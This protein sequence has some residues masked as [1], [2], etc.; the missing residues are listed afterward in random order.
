MLWMN[1]LFI[2]NS[3]QNL[4]AF[5]PQIK[6]AGLNE[7]LC[8]FRNPGSMYYIHKNGLRDKAKEEYIMTEQQI[9]NEPMLRFRVKAMSRPVQE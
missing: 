7:I 4:V 1:I 9:A 6:T 8:V 5:H 3:S 2:F